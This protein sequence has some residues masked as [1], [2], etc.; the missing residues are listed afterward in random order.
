MQPN[1]RGG[2]ANITFVLKTLITPFN[3][4]AQLLSTITMMFSCLFSLYLP[5]KTTATVLLNDLP[6]NFKFL[7]QNYGHAKVDR[8]EYRKSRTFWEHEYLV[9]TVMETLGAGQ[10]VYL[11]ADRLD[12]DPPFSFKWRRSFITRIVTNIAYCF[13]LPVVSLLYFLAS[14]V[15]WIFPSSSTTLPSPAAVPANY[16][17]DPPD[18]IDRLFLLPNIDDALDMQDQCS[19]DTLMT[20]DL[21]LL[22]NPIT[23]EHFLALMKTTSESTPPY[24]LIHSQCFWYAYTIWATCWTMPTAFL[25]REEL[26]FGRGDSVRQARMSE[27]IKQEAKAVVDQE[28]NAARQALNGPEEAL[29]RQLAALKAGQL[30]AVRQGWA[31]P[32][33]LPGDEVQPT[34][35][36]T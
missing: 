29:Q 26:P 19:Y 4:L 13:L 17:R 25:L 20:M 16:K 30:E 1:T 18:A 23:L 32:S 22:Q 2:C 28:F 21:S 15:L 12:D 27:T 7:R 35:D 36:E 9:L 33:R 14:P 5:P 31:G 6:L 8:V 24:H 34:S 10:T 11:L 3:N